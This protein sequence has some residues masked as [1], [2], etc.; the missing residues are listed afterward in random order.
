MKYWRNSIPAAVALLFAATVWLDVKTLSDSLTLGGSIAVLLL[1]ATAATL[2]DRTAEW[3]QG[4][5]IGSGILL[6]YP[7]NAAQILWGVAS[8][9]ALAITLATQH[10][11]HHPA[12]RLRLHA[13]LLLLW[14]ASLLTWFTTPPIVVQSLLQYWWAPLALT[15]AFWQGIRHESEQKYIEATWVVTALALVVL[16]WTHQ[17]PSIDGVVLGLVAL[18][19]WLF[20]WHHLI[21]HKQEPFLAG[22]LKLTA[23]VVLSLALLK[24]QST[25]VAGAAAFGLVVLNVVA[26]SR[27]RIINSAILLVLAAAALFLNGDWTVL[28][29][30]VG[31][32]SG[33]NLPTLTATLAQLPVLG[34]NTIQPLTSRMGLLAPFWLQWGILGIIGLLVIIFT[35]MQHLLWRYQLN[36]NRRAVARWSALLVGLVV[37]GLHLTSADLPILWLVL[38]IMGIATFE[39]LALRGKT[40]KPHIVFVLPSFEKIGPNEGILALAKRLAPHYQFTAIGLVYKGKHRSGLSLRAHFEAAGVETIQMHLRLLGPLGILPLYTTL[41]RLEP[42]IVHTNT[43]RPD[44]YGRTAAHYIPK[45]KIISTI[46]TPSPWLLSKN[47]IQRFFAWWDRKSS[48]WVDRLVVISPSLDAFLEEHKFGTKKQ[49]LVIPNGLEA[50]QF[51]APQARVPWRRK[52]GLRQKAFVVGSIGRAHPD[53]GIMIFIAAA[54]KLHKDYPGMQFLFVGKGPQLRALQEEVHRRNL[55]KVFLFAG[56]QDAIAQVLATLD[57]FVLP[58]FYEGLGMVLVQAQLAGLPCIGSDTTGIRDILHSE[59]TGLLVPPREAQALAQA[60][61]RIYVDGAL[62]HNIAQQG[63]ASALENFSAHKMAQSY[64]ALYDSLLAQKH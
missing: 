21:D 20:L 44:L 12:R 23:V 17:I 57:C 63:K 6:V 46:R 38:G 31:N 2:Q 1:L 10:L 59:K 25:A 61:A 19:A 54:A 40:R 29:Q 32:I 43:L 7:T 56:E 27:R 50:Q 39:P 58:S 8:F 48:T 13:G 11:H 53:K 26:F 9:A 34:N 47:P 51:Q 62:A 37:I 55:S 4:L 3:L 42:A 49:R 41:R 5:I 28:W 24:T 18:P 35:L 22:L 52:L 33:T 14:L 60:I 30:G 15:L 45:T 64:Q 36:H 16:Q